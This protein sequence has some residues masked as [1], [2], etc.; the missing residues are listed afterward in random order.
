[1]L[2]LVI[3]PIFEADFKPCSYEAGSVGA[4]EV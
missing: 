4:H 1:V 3:E 2:K